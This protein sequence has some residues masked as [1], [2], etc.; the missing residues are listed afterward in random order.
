VVEE[1]GVAL[2]VVPV[3]ATVEA[4]LDAEGAVNV[5]VSW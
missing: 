4:V 5:N 1:A 2:A 3:D